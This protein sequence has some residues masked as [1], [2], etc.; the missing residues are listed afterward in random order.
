[1]AV[2]RKLGYLKAFKIFETQHGLVQF[3]VA[4]NSS[5]PNRVLLSQLAPEIRH[6]GICYV[7]T[8][9][10]CSNTVSKTQSLGH[11]WRFLCHFQNKFISQ[12]DLLLSYNR[13]AAALENLT[14]IN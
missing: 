10:V 7:G 3:I 4:I 8:E 2:T 6:G 9:S 5:L 1:M 13:N 14:K 12:V 11:I